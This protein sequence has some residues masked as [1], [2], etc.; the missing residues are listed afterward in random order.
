MNT[1]SMI[2]GLLLAL[3]VALL[4]VARLGKQLDKTTLSNIAEGTHEDALTRLT[5]AAITTRHLLY[6]V[7]SDANHIAVCGAANIPMGTVPDEASAAEENVALLLLGG[8]KG[9][10]LMVAS[11]AI[12]AGEQVYTAANGKVQ[13][14]PGST[15][16]VYLVGTALT[17]ADADGDLIE[18]DPCVAQKTV[19]A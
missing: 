14:L 5:D 6:K 12:T 2:T 17:S 7:G 13:D 8:A 3:T 15:A 16:T 19:V 11:E 18:V 4:V 9:S 1:I 10:R